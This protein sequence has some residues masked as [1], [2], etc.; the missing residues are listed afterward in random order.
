MAAATLLIESLQLF[1][2]AGRDASLGDLITNSFG[3][4]IG[5]ALGTRTDRIMTPTS[6]TATTLLGGWAAAWLLIQV[7]AAF[8]LVPVLPRSRYFAQIARALPHQSPFVGSIVNVSVDGNRLTNGEQPDGARLRGQLLRSKGAVLEAIVVPTGIPPRFS[9]IV[10]VVDHEYREILMLARRGPD[11][12]FSLR[13]GADVM[14]LQPRQ[15]LLAH[16]FPPRGSGADTLVIE[17][18]YSRREVRLRAVTPDTILET[19][20][21]PALADAWRLIVPLPTYSESGPLN[22]AYGALWFFALTLPAGYW[23][24]FAVGRGANGVASIATRV[25]ALLLP[26]MMVGFVGV[27]QVFGLTLVPVAGWLASMAGALT[28]LLVA[29]GRRDPMRAAEIQNVRPHS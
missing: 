1:V 25:S 7:L 22:G 2:I 23:G 29:Y 17:G 8:A 9:P 4:S 10:A 20:N 16:A 26:I 12:V 19:S 14:K 11:V 13:T 18:I 21:V 24:R 6:S 28:G 5:F 27:P 3:G 15:Y